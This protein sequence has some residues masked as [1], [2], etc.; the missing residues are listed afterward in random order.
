[1]KSENLKIKELTLI[2]FKKIIIINQ[3]IILINVKKLYININ[4]L[5]IIV[6]KF[7]LFY[8]NCTTSYNI[9]YVNF[10]ILVKKMIS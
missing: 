3:I 7:S 5:S 1:M 8:V 4:S 2:K 6:N 10:Y 9:Y